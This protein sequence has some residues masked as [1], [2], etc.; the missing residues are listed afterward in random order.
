M[1]CVNFRPEALTMSAKLP[2]SDL[3]RAESEVLTRIHREIA[4]E[5]NTPTGSHNS[6]SSGHS[7]Q[8]GHTSSVAR[9][10]T[11]EPKDK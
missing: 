8:G 3:L 1:V 11:L 7:S 5:N 6:H 2:L 9:V 4:Q 10:E